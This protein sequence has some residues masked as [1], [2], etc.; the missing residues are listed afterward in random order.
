MGPRQKTWILA[1]ISL[2]LIFV[3]LFTDLRGN[4][5]YILTRR[6]YKV[7]A[8]LLTG[9][10]IGFSTVVFQTITQ[11]RILTPNIMG[12]DSLYVLIHTV[13][14]FTFGSATLTAMDKNLQ[15]LVLVALMIF[16]SGFLYKFLFKR[17]RQN[18]YF[19]LLIGF[20]AGTLFDSLS[21]VMQVL[22]DPN[23]FLI[24]QD[25]MF[26]SINNI[27]TDLVWLAFALF[28]L[29]TLYFLRYVKFLDVLA[30]GRDMAVNLGVDFD[31]VV[32]RLLAIVAVL[33][34]I[35]TA[36]V[37]PMTFLGLLVANISYE[38]YKTYMHRYLIAGAIFISFIAL[39]GGQ[40]VVER[41]YQFST[42]I[43]VIINFIGG[44]Y[45]IYLLI[46]ENRK[47]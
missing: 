19:L 35:S 26:S 7:L 15:F 1:G 45:F 47:W 46:R 9:A 37:G 39:A 11:N 20:I 18:L 42:P 12:L 6:F 36:L 28:L 3:F 31:H 27:N 17:G 33:L 25:R 8:I 43:S 41:V 16:F 30:L 23:E 21:S 24:V 14:V 34:S 2:M 22:M 10:A 44:V 29:S 4:I 5:D 38:F 40:L 32:K 13:I